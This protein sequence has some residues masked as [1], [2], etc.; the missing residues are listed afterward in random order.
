M[1]SS[2]VKALAPGTISNR[3]K[4]AEDYLKFALTFNVPYLSPSTTQV[5]MYAQFLA[6]THAA[7]TSIK[8]S[9]SG[10]KTWVAE[11]M[12]NINA[13]LSPQLAQLIKGFT[14]N[15]T[16]V[17]V[18]AAPLSPRHIRIICDFALNTPGVEP[19]IKPAI[20]LGYS[21][22]L[23][24]SNLLSRTMSEWGGPHTLLARDVHLTQKGLSITIRSSK[25]RSRA[26]PLAFDLP[27]S[28]DPTYCPV[29]AWAVY[30]AQVNPWALGPAFIHSD[31]RPLTARQVSGIMRLA[32]SEQSDINPGQVSL[33]SLRRGAT[34]AAVESGLSLETI[35]IRGTWNSTSGVQPYLPRSCSV[36]TVPV[37]NL[38]E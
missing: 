2:Y 18:Q 10:A 12:G 6:N 13:F 38:A 3:K 16:H 17:P 5:C 27:P 21:C 22:F 34:H 4:Q 8:N 33:H 32:L 29:A 1:F 15:S 35:M 31:G 36:R 19:A 30:K 37:N 7:P 23:R 24:G 9:M 11:H 28:Q 26:S 20:L 25:T 14:K